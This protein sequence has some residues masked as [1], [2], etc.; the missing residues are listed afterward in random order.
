MRVGNLSKSGVRRERHFSL[1]MLG[2]LAGIIIVFLIIWGVAIGIGVIVALFDN[3]GPAGDDGD[4]EN[5]VT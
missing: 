5:G 1:N 2:I 3:Q 4:D